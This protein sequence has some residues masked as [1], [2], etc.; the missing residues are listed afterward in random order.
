MAIGFGRENEPRQRESTEYDKYLGTLVN[1]DIA[2]GIR[3][4]GVLDEC[5]PSDHGY[6]F[7]LK[8][9]IAYRQNGTPEII[10]KKHIMLK[11][12]GN[13]I[14]IYPKDQ[15]IESYLT[16]ITTLS[17]KKKSSSK[18]LRSAIVNWFTK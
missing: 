8:P 1:V 16:E 7:H 14:A 6:N 13:A 9:T 3:G 15:S 12:N 18:K 5:I 17:Q 4:T 2:G 11:S 10:D